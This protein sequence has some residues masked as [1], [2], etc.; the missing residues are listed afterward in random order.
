MGPVE[1]QSID[2]GVHQLISYLI[3]LNKY[4]ST[5]QLHFTC[6]NPT[7]NSHINN[8][9]LLVIESCP[10]C[11]KALTPNWEKVNPIFEDAATHFPVQIAR[12]VYELCASKSY[13]KK[14]HLISIGSFVRSI[15][16]ISSK[17]QK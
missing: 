8:F 15:P 5:M 13:Y 4:N 1:T 12:P 6:T 14:L 2:A 3:V 7:C 11:N 10:E 9:E 17:V 16:H